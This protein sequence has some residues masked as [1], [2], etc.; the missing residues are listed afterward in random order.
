MPDYEIEDIEFFCFLLLFLLFSLCVYVC[1]F[2]LLICFNKITTCSLD[3]L[4]SSLII[5]TAGITAFSYEN[6]LRV[7]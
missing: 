3:L 1:V 2:R 4:L 5:Y 7:D 6:V